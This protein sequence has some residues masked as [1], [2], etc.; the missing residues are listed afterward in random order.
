MSSSRSFMVYWN[1]GLQS[2]LNAFL[3]MTWVCVCVCAC[4]CT[5][6]C[7][8]L[9]NLL[10]C[11]PPGSSTHRIFQARITGV[12]CQS[13]LQGIFPTQGL[14]PRLLHFLH[15]QV[16]SLPLNHWGSSFSYER[17]P[18]YSFTCTCSVFPAPLIEELSFPHCMFLLPLLYIN[19]LYIH[20]F[21]SDFSAPSIDE[22][23][24]VLVPCCF[25]YHSFVF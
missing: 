13:L 14:S 25:D 20:E 18:I 9:C 16:D 22:S 5:Q 10:D 7:L 1:L 3:Y 2:I 15:W 4:T 23:V 19:W 17:V 11:S 6:S 21:I 24:F 12:G 8:T